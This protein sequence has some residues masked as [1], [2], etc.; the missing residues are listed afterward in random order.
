MPLI[1]ALGSAESGIGG[2]HWLYG[3][4]KVSLHY[5]EI[6][7]EKAIKDEGVGRR[8]LAELLIGFF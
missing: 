6:L 8:M 1:P 2:Q 3:K 5:V 4:F 7:S